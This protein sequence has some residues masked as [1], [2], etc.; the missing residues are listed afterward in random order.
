MDELNVATFDI[1]DMF[2][3]KSYPKDTV[4]VYTD[5]ATA[6]ELQKLSKEAADAVVRRDAEEGKRIE[7]EIKEL[8]KKGEASK[9]VFHLTGVSREMKDNLIK[10]VDEKFPDET[11]FLNRVK[12]NAEKADFLENKWWALHVERIIAPNGAARNAPTEDDIKL[13]RGNLAESETA[14]V[15]AGI[16]GLTEGVK[17]GFEALAQEHDF[18]S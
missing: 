6:Y 3:G 14:K 11:D 8:V 18:L 4:T 9:Y 13:I 16:K 12:P 15:T 10:S 7:S 1:A 2:S 17:S 5:D